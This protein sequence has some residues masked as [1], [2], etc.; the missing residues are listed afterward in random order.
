MTMMDAALEYIK[1]GFRIFPVSVD[2][3]PLTEHGF[4][5]ATQIILGVKEYW[6]KCPDAGIGI[7]TDG[8]IVLDFD[9]K[10]G[11]L[12]SKEVIETK[13]GKLPRTR[14]HRT[15]GGGLHYIYRNA[16]GSNV[17]N[18]AG[19]AGYSGVDIRANGGYIVAPPS[20]HTSGNHYEVLDNSPIIPAP[21]WLIELLKQKPSS[22]V[23][24]TPG[25]G[26][27]IPEGQRNQTLARL[28]G[29]MRRQGMSED[30]VYSV[31]L[32][33][34]KRC[35]P[36]PLTDH[37]VLNI[38]QSITRYIPTP[39]N[40]KIPK[41]LETLD[42]LESVESLES[43]ECLTSV[44][45][46]RSSLEV[47][48]TKVEPSKYKNISK[49]VRDW[50]ILHQDETF[51]LDTICRQLGINDAEGRNYVTV[52]LHYE[53]KVKNLEKSN[54]IY[55]YINNN[56]TKV[57]WYKGNVNNGYIDITFPS[58]HMAQDLSYFSF[59]D[60]VRLS[61]GSVTVV[62]GQT[63]AGKST[64]ARHLVWDN[65]DK[66]QVRYM[67]SQT[68]GAAFARYA[69]N[70]KWANPM[71]DA[72]TPKFELIERYED[73]QDLIIPNG[74]NVVDWLDAD[75]LEYFKIGMAIKAMQV[76]VMGGILVVMIQKNGNNAEYGDGGIKSAKWAD[77]YLTLDYNREKNFTRMTIVKAKEWIGNHDPNGKNYGFEITNYGSQ[78]DHIR[79]V[80]KCTSCWGTGRSKA[81]SD[82][83]MCAGV[84]W[85]DGQ[86][87]TKPHPDEYQEEAPF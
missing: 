86:K 42:S 72:N 82:C 48:E 10:S 35:Q 70:M 50:I 47:L 71:K 30:E 56:I 9:V 11:G 27:P 41:S 80:K 38:T 44:E 59:Q 12:E 24:T 57:I 23:S 67:V 21:E 16:V 51:N 1:E 37:E 46:S 36:E 31:L 73:F 63:N 6:N 61:P 17:R 87:V 76:K 15:G 32:I 33:A 8:Y 3:K 26:D 7:R 13:Y 34:N 54:G 64:I 55:R 84:G 25:I 66:H 2:K 74:I 77:L 79:E 40:I 39:D 52:K 19:F 29:V 68:S 14:T 65:M 78:I 75:K 83:S 85:I 45:K 18:A 43:K 20:L 5:D 49:V 22:S 53:V 69:N 81:G 60:S 4:K 28:A 62:A 58:S